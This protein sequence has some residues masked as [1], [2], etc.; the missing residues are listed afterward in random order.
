MNV[1]EETA[2]YKI[3][4]DYRLFG[5][6]AVDSHVEAEI[7]KADNEATRMKS[8]IEKAKAEREKLAESAPRR[9]FLLPVSQAKRVWG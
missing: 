1:S 8:E 5:I 4:I 2:A 3:D 6:P 9:A 7:Q